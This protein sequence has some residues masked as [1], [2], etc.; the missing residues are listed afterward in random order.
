[1]AY[2]PR[3]TADDMAFAQAAAHNA[4][5][6]YVVKNLATHAHYD[7]LSTQAGSYML[8]TT[9]A[10]TVTAANSSSLATSRTLARDIHAIYVLHIADTNAHDAADSTN[11]IAF[12][13]PALAETLA[14]LITWANQCKAAFNAHR[15]QAGKHPTNDTT[16]VVTAANATNQGELDTLLNDIKVQII[17]HLAAAPGSVIVAP[18]AA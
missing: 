3:K 2:A 5:A 10:R 17:A 18:Q 11:T 13:L 16:N 1:M 9:S 6:R 14:N 15:T 8:P 12:G 4:L 7:V